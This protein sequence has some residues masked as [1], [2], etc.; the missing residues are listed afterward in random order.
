MKQ[1]ILEFIFSLRWLWVIVIFLGYRIIASLIDIIFSNIALK[2]DLMVRDTKYNEDEIINHLKYIIDETLN[3]YVIIN[4][5]AKDIPY[6]TTVI[7]TEIREYLTEEVPK[8]I[9]NVLLTH[10]SYIYND[11]YV[12]KFIGIQIYMTVVDYKVRYNLDRN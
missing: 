7:E 4:I 2:H 11:N 5:T 3:E 1:V 6:I 12:G 8:R 10:L 9:S